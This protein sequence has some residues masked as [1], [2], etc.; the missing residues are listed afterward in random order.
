MELSELI[1]EL[2]SKGVNNGIIAEIVLK[3]AEKNGT[4]ESAKK[5]KLEEQEYSVISK[6]ELINVHL[7]QLF[8]KQKEWK[9]KDLRRELRCKGPNLYRCLEKLTQMELLRK[10][11]VRQFTKTSARWPKSIKVHSRKKTQDVYPI[12]E[13]LFLVGSEGAEF[14]VEDLVDVYGEGCPRDQAQRFLTIYS[15]TKHIVERTRQPKFK[16]RA[17]YR[18]TKQFAENNSLM[19]QTLKN[20]KEFDEQVKRGI[21]D[22][23]K[24]LSE[25]EESE[26]QTRT[27]DSGVPQ[28]RES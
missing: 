13:A 15:A 16:S 8:N 2:S 12:I 23:R 20:A 11:G 19:E 7:R 27:A 5:E 22:I 17:K 25:E 24:D 10:S 1:N 18:L 14:T 6:D 9:T 28:V 21:R 3:A 4:S 26:A